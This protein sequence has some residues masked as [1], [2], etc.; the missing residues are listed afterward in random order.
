MR[1]PR[2][3]LRDSAG[4]APASQSSPSGK[5]ARSKGI[6]KSRYGRAHESNG[7]HIAKSTSDPVEERWSRL[8]TRLGSRACPRAMWGR[9]PSAVR[10]SEAPQSR[11]RDHSRRPGAGSHL[12]RASC[13]RACPERPDRREGNRMGGMCAHFLHLP[14]TYNTIDS[15]TL[16]SSEVARGK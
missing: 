11:C 9:P 8:P 5:D 10:R 13:G 6:R 12:S 4:F 7:M 2:L 1:F 14:T 15:T 16:S 3:Q